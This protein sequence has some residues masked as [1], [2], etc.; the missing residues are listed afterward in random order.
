ME[1]ARKATSFDEVVLRVLQKRRQAKKK[2]KRGF[3][4]FKLR[5]RV[6]ELNLQSTLAKQSGCTQL[7]NPQALISTM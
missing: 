1:S 6:K 2:T 5:E 4:T 7:Y 3:A